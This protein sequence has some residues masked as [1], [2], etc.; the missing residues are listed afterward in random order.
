MP[1]PV[2]TPLPSKL[3]RAI[4]ELILRDQI[5]AGGIRVI[6]NNAA[7][8]REGVIRD[9]RFRAG[10]VQLLTSGEPTVVVALK[11]VRT[12]CANCT[13][14]AMFSCPAPCSNMLKPARGC[15]EYINNASRGS[16][17]GSD[18]P[19]A[20]TPLLPPRLA[21]PSTYRSGTSSCDCQSR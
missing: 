4:D 15:A 9:R 16:A 21:S 12:E 14:P 5:E 6:E 3:P 19:A 17:S 7:R 11:S 20:S 13:A 18:L 8:P 2:M 10:G 1:S